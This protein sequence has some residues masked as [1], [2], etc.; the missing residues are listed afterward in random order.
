MNQILVQLERLRNHHDKALET[1]ELSYLLDLSHILRV[2]TELVDALPKHYPNF[3]NK[4][5][6]K[7]AAPTKKLVRQ[8]SKDQHVLSYL[9]CGVSTNVDAKE[10]VA[11]PKEFSQEASVGFTVNRN[12]PPNNYTKFSFI[13]KSIDRYATT[14]IGVENSF[15]KT[16]DK[17]KV[18]R[19][20][21]KSWMQTE[22][23]RI[24]Y[25][26]DNELIR[27]IINRETLIKRAANILDASHS[28][29]KIDEGSNIF[30]DAIKK[31]LEFKCGGL[32]LVYFLL[33]SI[34]QDILN[35][36]SQYIN[37][38]A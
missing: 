16:L 19:Y 30:D 35:V 38:Q 10:N 13:D 24:S 5:N 12:G 7:S 26:K 23:V 29:L 25:K 8:I 18:N 17:Q 34:A 22:I 14:F 27:K 3:S 4:K 6:F 11:I 36:A 37:E 2:W 15:L 9:P 28:S 31:L 32:P 21:Y 1:Y 33:L 20:N